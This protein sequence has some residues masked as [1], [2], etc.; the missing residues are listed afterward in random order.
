[1]IVIADME[2]LIAAPLVQLVANP[3]SAVAHLVEVGEFL[4]VEMEEIAWGLVLI[5]IVRFFL[6][7]RGCQGSTGLPEPKTY[8]RAGHA[9]LPGNP[10]RRLAPPSSTYG[11]D[12]ES[13]LVASRQAMGLAGSILEARLAL[14][15][16]PLD[17]LVPGALTEPGHG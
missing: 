2:H 17:P 15:S 14:A 16:K 6:D 3:G 7:E 11:L 13:K 9:E 12:D 8:G 4:C 1:V 10:D 5:P